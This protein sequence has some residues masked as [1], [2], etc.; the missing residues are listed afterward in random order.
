V[1]AAA[2]QPRRAGR[3]PLPDALIRHIALE[4]LALFERG[5]TRGIL[6][7]LAEQES[8]RLGRYVAPETVR[9]WVRR[10]REL[11]F[12]SKG[13]PGKAYAVAGPRLIAEEIPKEGE[14]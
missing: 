13:V 8:E 9:D 1:R 10:A 4:Y 7:R 3:K 14:H 6:V 2:D 11:E 12:L 5:V